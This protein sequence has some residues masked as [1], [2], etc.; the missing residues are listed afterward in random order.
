MAEAY[1]IIVAAI[2]VVF[3]VPALIVA[4]ATPLQRLALTLSSLGALGMTA[5]MAML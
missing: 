2:F 1:A 4:L 5:F 3:A